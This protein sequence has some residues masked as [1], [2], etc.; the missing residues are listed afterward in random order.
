MPC[1]VIIEGAAQGVHFP[2]TL[3][4]TSIGREDTCTIQIVDNFVSRKHLQI[5][6]DEALGQLGELGHRQRVDRAHQP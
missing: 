1:L 2:L 6:L 4:L 5:R 3:P